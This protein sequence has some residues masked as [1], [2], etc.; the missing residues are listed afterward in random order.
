MAICELVLFMPGF[1]PGMPFRLREFVG[2]A[3]PL[4]VGA[5]EGELEAVSSAAAALTGA[6]AA[7]STVEL[8]GDEGVGSWMSEGNLASRL[9]GRRR[10]INRVLAGVGLGNFGMMA[11]RKGA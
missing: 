3:W 7:E 5:F 10:T 9:A 6:R 8:A 11:A 1:G 2:S 4:D